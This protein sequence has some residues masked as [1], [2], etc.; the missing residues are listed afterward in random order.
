MKIKTT[1]LFDSIFLFIVGILFVILPSKM[2]EWIGL[3]IGIYFILKAVIGYFFPNIFPLLKLSAGTNLFL[4]ILSL[5]LWGFLV[6]FIMLLIGIILLGNGLSL[7]TKKPLSFKNRETYLPTIISILMTVS[8]IIIFIASLANAGHILGL[9][10]GIILI[11]ISIIM[12]IN[13]L[14]KKENETFVEE[15]QTKVE[16]QA[17][18]IDAEIISENEVE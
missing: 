15:P 17:D 1:E 16:T 4:G 8:G 10:T 2:V 3:I 12:F 13:L 14:K 9:I 18:V 11:I 5:L 7:L 6:K